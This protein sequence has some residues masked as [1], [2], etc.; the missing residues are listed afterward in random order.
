M[1]IISIPF[2]LIWIGLKTSM[3]AW[4]FLAVA[5]A[6]V[7]DIVMSVIGEKLKHGDDRSKAEDESQV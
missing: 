1:L 5:V 7:G 2:F 6:V 4:Y 3:P